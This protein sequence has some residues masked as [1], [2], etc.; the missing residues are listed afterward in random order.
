MNKF[1]FV[2]L[3]LAAFILVSYGLSYVVGGVSNKIAIIPIIGAIST[4]GNYRLQEGTSSSDIL[5]KIEN[6]EEDFSVKGIILEIN[7]P[8]GTVVASKEIAD[9]IKEIE[10]P[11]VALIRGSGASGAYWIASASD[12]IVAD[13]LSVIGSIGVTSSYLEFSGLLEEY[14]VSYQRLV[15]GEFKDVGS[16]F[17][18][19]TERERGLLM[20]KLDQIHNF[21]VKEVAGN[22]NLSVASVGKL[23]TGEFFLGQEAIKVGLVDELGGRE[24]A[25]NASK[26]LA[27]ITD[28]DVVKYKE[29]AGFFEYLLNSRIPFQIGQGIGSSLISVDLK[30][31]EIT[32]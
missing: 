5:D 6:A 31:P 17:K 1:L 26:R 30:K 19:L 25:V 15:T 22:R 21:F 9:K 3:V 4:D 10:K 28:A 14:K 8:G 11:V 23:A 20:R 7:S 32:A 29:A 13:E 27:N 16:P 2:I 24:E 12:Y 18:D